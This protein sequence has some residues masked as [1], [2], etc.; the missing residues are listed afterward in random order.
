MPT[1][2][3]H[4][5]SLPPLPTPAPL[6]LLTPSYDDNEKENSDSVSQGRFL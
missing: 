6:L 5:T 4:S 3:L 2:S 1:P